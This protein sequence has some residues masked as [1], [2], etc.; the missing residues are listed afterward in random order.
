[1]KQLTVKKTFNLRIKGKPSSAIKDASPS[2]LAAVLPSSIPFIKPKLSKKI[3]DSILEGE[4]LFFDKNNPSIQFVS[5]M[6][7]VIKH[8]EYGE[9]RSLEAVIIEQDKKS[10][11]SFKPVSESELKAFNKEDLTTYL[12]D[13][14]TWSFLRAFP[15]KKIA[16][17]NSEIPAIYVTLDDLE[18]FKPQ[19]HLYAQGKEVAFSYGLTILS[20][21][22]SVVEV[23]GSD[24]LNY[25]GHPLQ[26]S[27][28]ISA[29]GHYPAT[30][31]GVVLY[32]NK[33]SAAENNSV[34]ISGQDVIRLAEGMLTGAYPKRKLVTVSGSLVKEPFHCW[35]NEG[36]P[37]TSILEGLDINGGEPYVILG[38]LFTGRRATIETHLGFYDDSIQ[39]IPK[40]NG[41]EFFNFFKLGTEKVG[42]SKSYLGAFF[43]SFLFSPTA[44]L[45]GGDRDCI[46]CSYCA[47]VCPVDL[48]PQY[49]FKYLKGDDIEGAMNNGVL[50]CTE[51]GLCTYVCPSK[52]NL[53]HHFKDAKRQLHKEAMG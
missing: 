53:D 52:I 26:S 51:C 43:K 19:S 24:T 3:K 50:D 5:P 14:G 36:D 41:A 23:I 31:P 37:L 29:K 48:L 20:K 8:I 15:F 18:P 17:P 22:S 13:Q 6:S 40:N 38:G 16:D 25:E 21:L 1:M 35:A 47:E 9:R 49:V 39:V 33:T 2:D 44:A 32:H 4:V 30:D 7:G 11:K 42:Y 45:N 46:S 12:T 10:P 27:I 34:Y 28:T